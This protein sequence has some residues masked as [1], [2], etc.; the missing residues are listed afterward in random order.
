VTPSGLRDVVALAS[1]ASA[2]I[3]AALTPSHAADGPLAAGAFAASAAA[4]ALAALAVELRPEATGPVLAAAVGLAG[5]L[6]AWAAAVTTGL[7]PLHPDPEP[8][9]GL[10]LV[11]KALE[12]AGLL[13]AARVLTRRPTTATERTRSC[14]T[15]ARHAPSGSS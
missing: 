6:A 11:T 10:G 13:A 7:P 2:G 14:A 12:A 9:D 5:L 15:S 1:A 8:V 3:H 4:L